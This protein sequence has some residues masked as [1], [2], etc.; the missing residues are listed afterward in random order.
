MASPFPSPSDW[1]AARRNTLSH[2]GL[3]LEGDE[4]GRQDPGNFGSARLRLL[5]CRLSP[6]DDVRTSI[7]HRVL[8][9]AAQAVP[10]VF[11]DLAY[12]PSASDAALMRK[13]GVPLWLATGSKRAPAEFDVVAISLSVQQE[14]A[15][16]PAALRGSGLRLD[17]AG[18]MAEA[19]HPLLL[20][21]GHGAPSTPFAHGDAAGPGSGGL[22]DAVCLGDGVVWLQ[23]FL[24]RW[25]ADQEAGRSKRERLESL[26]RE[27]PGTYVPAFYRHEC[28]D[29]R[30]AAVEPL[31]PGLPMPVQHRQDPMA[32]WLKDYDGAHI[33][34]SPEE[35]EETLPL[36]AGCAYRCR[37]CLTGW[38]RREF[39]AAT[40]EE[41]LGA[42]TRFKAAMVN[43]D[44]NLLASDAC[45]IAG[46]EPILD[47]LCP[48]FRRVSVKSLSVASLVRR[49]E[50]IR[51][52]RKLAKHEFTFGVEGVSARL[53]AYLGKPA[54]AA[55]LLRIAQH[56][57]GGGLRQM[58]LFFIATGLE[59]ERDLA[60]LGLLLKSLRAQAPACRI[61]ASF[62]PLFLAPFTPLQFAPIRPVS[63]EMEDALSARVREA[64]GEFRWSAHPDEIAL[65]NRLCRAGRAATPLLIEFSDH[66]LRYDRQLDPGLTRE[67][68]RALPDDSAEK[69]LHSVFPWS[70]LQAAADPQTLWTSYQ[71]ACRD[72]Q[73]AP[74]PAAPARPAPPRAAP[75]P[76]PPSNPGAPERRSFWAWLS[77][78]RARQPDHV[79]VRAL[80][81]D[82]FASWP[83]G[84]AAYLGDPR[85]LR[86]PGASGLVLAS[87]E[88]K[89]GTRIPDAP[90]GAAPSAPP[91]AK[92]RLLAPADL[93]GLP[94][95][96]CVFDIRWL[97]AKPA[98]KILNALRQGRAKH[99]TLRR[100]ADRW[101]I[102]ERA[103][104]G[105]TGIVAAREAPGQTIL[106]AQRRPALLEDDPDLLPAGVVHAILV[107][108]DAPCRACAG[109][110]FRTLRSIGAE[111]PPDCFD[112]LTKPPRS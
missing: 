31:L 22:V 44:L 111:A 94:E 18:R 2:G 91:P 76:P 59:E 24:R 104:R 101:H 58:K 21:G 6:H 37:F 8:L 56:L 40:R 92:S 42:A 45:G 25:I 61:I 3:W 51:L 16:L 50:S 78:D 80:F 27:L 67:L 81:R 83:E 55:D 49:P 75:T 85:L 29:G 19:A 97:D 103:F 77:P 36:S 69:D 43:A 73:E 74:E 35:V 99:Q 100:G 63:R 95:E 10:G 70:D 57:S 33:P 4:P 62:M 87:A 82:R 34:F 98:E 17:F 109:A 9:C 54:S 68:S 93:S 64:G 48:L 66:G 96:S 38:M 71:H 112:C 30:L 12:F 110:A 106:Y 65:M 39:S 47:S 84:V 32:A 23:E 79:I 46:L 7:S 11:A 107:R 60:E 108:S 90:E 88:F 15:N 28:R 53:R 72:L 52:L 5:I 20:L 13:D 102:V 41:L 14:A 86:P 26:A 1:F 89:P 105:R